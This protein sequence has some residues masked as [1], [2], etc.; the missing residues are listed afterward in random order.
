MT[1][2][3]FYIQYRN[4]TYRETEYKTAR[5][6]KRAYE[7]YDKQPEDSAKGWGW[8][9]KYEAPTLDQQIRAKKLTK[10]SK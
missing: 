8:D 10:D 9:T 2:A 3:Y 7:L 6:A 4:G 5:M 1:A